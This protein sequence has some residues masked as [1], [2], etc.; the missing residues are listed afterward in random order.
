LNFRH[1]TSSNISSLETTQ[2]LATLL[3]ALII[4]QI[5]DLHFVASILLMLHLQHSCIDPNVVVS[6]I[7]IPNPKGEKPIV[8]DN[9]NLS[10]PCDLV[11]RKQNYNCTKKFQDLWATKLPWVEMCL[12][13]NGSLHNVKCMICNQVEEKTSYLL[14]SGTHFASMKVI[15]KQKNILV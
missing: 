4:I 8:D 6:S 11:S 10:I 9:A 1:R 15:K 2:V 12:R 14:L 3:C 5:F 13:S 7:I